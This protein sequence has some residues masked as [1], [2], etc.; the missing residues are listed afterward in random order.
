ME[1]GLDP[2]SQ[3]IVIIGHWNPRIFTPKWIAKGRLTDQEEIKI[4]FGVG[5]GDVTQK[6]IFD[7]IKMTVLQRRVTFQML[8]TTSEVA[9]RIENIAITLLNDL[10]HTPISAIGLNHD[11]LVHDPSPGI[12]SAFDLKDN[13]LLTDGGWKITESSVSRQLLMD[14]QP[15]LTLGMRHDADGKVRINLNFELRSDSLDDAKDFIDGGLRRTAQTAAQILKEYAIDIDLLNDKP[16][17]L[18]A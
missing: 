2:V 6:F 3:R 10:S 13:N 15:P 8:E 7:D 9:K 12:L 1:V 11:L 17:P 18:N 16:I 5:G 14:D 4:E